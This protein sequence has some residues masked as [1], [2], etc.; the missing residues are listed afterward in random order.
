MSNNVPTGAPWQP[1]R[2]ADEAPLTIQ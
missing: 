2:G 1:A